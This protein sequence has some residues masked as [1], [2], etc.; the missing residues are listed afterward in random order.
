MNID[1]AHC[2]AT[3]VYGTRIGTTE[4]IKCSKLNLR[5]HIFNHCNGY[6]V[7]NDKSNGIKAKQFNSIHSS[8]KTQ[9]LAEK[10]KEKIRLTEEFKQQNPQKDGES[11]ADYFKVMDKYIKPKLKEWEEK[12][13][14]EH[15]EP[16]KF[17]SKQP[18][19]TRAI[20]L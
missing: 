17:Q 20:E 11:T 18:T 8:W 4:G 2:C 3:C 14:E 10:K 9:K 7:N 16:A 19:T 13:R 6:D 12:F 5:T 15:P 1:I